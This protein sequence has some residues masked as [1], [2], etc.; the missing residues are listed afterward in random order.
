MQHLNQCQQTHRTMMTTQTNPK[1]NL[2]RGKTLNQI[3]TQRKPKGDNTT[4]N[5]VTWDCALCPGVKFSDNYEFMRHLYKD[6]QIQPQGNS[7]KKLFTPLHFGIS[8][9]GHKIPT[10]VIVM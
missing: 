5:V 6:H 8:G 10:S 3:E 7:G 1:R 4:S 2:I 9:K